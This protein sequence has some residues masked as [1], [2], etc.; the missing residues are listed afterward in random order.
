MVQEAD[1]PKIKMKHFVF[2]NNRCGYFLHRKVNK[3]T[4]YN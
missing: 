2:F 3:A 4:V 1:P